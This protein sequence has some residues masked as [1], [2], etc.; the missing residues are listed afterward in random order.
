MK[1]RSCKNYCMGVMGPRLVIKVNNNCN[2]KCYFC[3]GHANKPL[4]T[5]DVKV[6]IQKAI[7][8]KDYPNVLILGGEPTLYEHLEELVREIAPYK[9]KISITTNGSNL[10]CLLPIV[11]YL[12]KIIVSIMHY[13]KKINKEIVGV[14]VEDDGK[15]IKTFASINPKLKLRVNCVMLKSGIASIEDMKKMADYAKDLGFNS[16]KFSEK[17]SPKLYDEDFVNISHLLKDYGIH[18]K[19]TV[20][21]GCYLEPPILEELFGIKTILNLTCIL[22]APT[23]IYKT[24]LT[25]EEM[26]EEI[27]P[28]QNVDSLVLHQN[29]IVYNNFQ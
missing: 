2:G 18:Q 28:M 3:V 11:Q 10:S 13:D 23:K 8:L 14:N 27:E 9:K 17:T 5:V 19:D 21:H 24:E 22:K 4:P 7:E 1:K 15:L 26:L 25:E 20:T 6:L 16:I 29:G 12:D